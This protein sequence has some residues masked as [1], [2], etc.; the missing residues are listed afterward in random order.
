MQRSGSPL[1]TVEQNDQES[2]LAFRS[3]ENLIKSQDKLLIS[4]VIQTKPRKLQPL[5]GGQEIN[6]DLS[7]VMQKSKLNAVRNESSAD[8][9]F[10]LPSEG[11]ND[12][13]K[14]EI[15]EIRDYLA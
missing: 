4:S 8:F 13:P 7:G 14:I 5:M 2:T 3:N 10:T 12:P 15:D 1:R 11:A 9:N 6:K